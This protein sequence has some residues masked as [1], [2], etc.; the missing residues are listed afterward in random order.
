[1]SDEAMWMERAQSVEA[2]LATYRQATEPALDR[3]RNFKA[4]FGVK[5][6]SDGSIII[7]YDKLVQRLGAESCLELRKVI[8]ETWSISGAPGEKPK[9]RVKAATA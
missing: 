9:V 3:V 6:K 7:D 8:D 1:M 5:E 2:K 4:N